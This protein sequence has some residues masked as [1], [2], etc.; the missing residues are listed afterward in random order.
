MRVIYFTRGATD[1]LSA[2]GTRGAHFLPLADGE[3]NPT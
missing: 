3:G 2:A 1:P